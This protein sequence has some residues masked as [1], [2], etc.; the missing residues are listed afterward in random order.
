MENIIYSLDVEITQWASVDVENLGI[1][2]LDD[3]TDAQILGLFDAYENAEYHVEEQ[4]KRSE[5]VDDSVWWKYSD[6]YR[7]LCE[8]RR[9][10]ARHAE[11]VS[12]GGE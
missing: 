3:L 10:R 7:E 9:W 12:N 11:L 4:E 1:T 8:K 6:K 2:D 5:Q